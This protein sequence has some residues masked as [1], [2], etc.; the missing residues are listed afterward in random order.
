MEQATGTYIM[1]VDSDDVLELNAC[2]LAYNQIEQNSNDL[3]IFDYTIY[4]EDL[5]K[6]IDDR[7][8]FI[9]FINILNNPH[10]EL[11]KMNNNFFQSAFAWRRI[12]NHKFLKENNIKF[13][14]FRFCEDTP[15]VNLA[16]ILANN[17]SILN[18][19]LYKY[20]RRKTALSNLPCN[21]RDA[22]DTRK[23][24]S[25]YLIDKQLYK[26]YL[27]SFVEQNGVSLLYWHRKSSH[28]DPFIKKAFKSEIIKYMDSL[29]K[30]Q[31]KK[32]I[33]KYFL[34]KY[35][36]MEIYYNLIYP[37]GKYCIYIPY[38]NFKNMLKTIGSYEI[39]Y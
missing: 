24:I 12:Y 8:H 22:I 6:I 28:I 14:K 2:E 35:S 1:I 13:L 38:K 25:D 39:F 15:F 34:F 5:T 10:I 16:Y 30:Y 27:E 7:N 36:I 32:T 21:W 33:I 17:I 9:P 23:F 3:V 29:R 31:N 20:R 26:P 11:S 4:N 19:S 37:I 18:K